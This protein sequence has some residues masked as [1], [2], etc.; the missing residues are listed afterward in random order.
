MAHSLSIHG[1]YGR[2]VKWTV[3]HSPEGLS[4]N[5]TTPDGTPEVELQLYLDGDQV[6][7]LLIELMADSD[8]RES[9]LDVLSAL[10]LIAAGDDD[11]SQRRVDGAANMMHRLAKMYALG[12]LQ[13]AKGADNA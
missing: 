10:D 6:A 1:N 4:L 13:G 7:A 3:R 2:E 9:A 11:E 8:V 5:V 12:R